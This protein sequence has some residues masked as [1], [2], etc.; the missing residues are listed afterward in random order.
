MN[1][2]EYQKEYNKQYYLKHKKRLIAKGRKYRSDPKIRERNNAQA[3]TY[4]LKNA[5]K[6]NAKIRKYR[7]DPKNIGSSKKVSFKEGG[8]DVFLRKL[9]TIL[10]L[11]TPT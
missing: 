5:D 2:K 7:S 10:N 3:R 1:R 6:I 8:L 9:L 4:R 11:N